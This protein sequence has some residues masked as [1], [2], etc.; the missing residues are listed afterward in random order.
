LAHSHLWRISLEQWEI[1]LLEDVLDTGLT[2]VFR[3]DGRYGRRVEV[4]QFVDLVDNVPKGCVYEWS[5][6]VLGLCVC[7]SRGRTCDM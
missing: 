3:K 1:G 5:Q 4:C 7:A 6:A 2:K